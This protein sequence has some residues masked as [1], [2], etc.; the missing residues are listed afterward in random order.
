MNR[1]LYSLNKREFA[2]H[3]LKNLLLFQN[4]HS[5]FSSAK[6]VFVKFFFFNGKEENT[7]LTEKYP[8][9]DRS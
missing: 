3:L 7:V 5:N 6:S 4:C 1:I 2:F 8:F 9:M